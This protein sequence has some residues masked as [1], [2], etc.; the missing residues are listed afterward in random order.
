MPGI[1]PKND[2]ASFLKVGVVWKL[3]KIVL[4]NTANYYKK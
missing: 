4:T 2:I 3:I 1:S